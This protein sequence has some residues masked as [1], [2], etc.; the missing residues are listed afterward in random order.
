VKA[1]GGVRLVT[2]GGVLP[3]PVEIAA[4]ALPHDKALPYVSGTAQWLRR[5]LKPEVLP[6]DLEAR[7]LAVPRAV[8]G[9]DAVLAAWEAGGRRFQAVVTKFDVH[10]LVALPG[11]GGDPEQRKQRVVDEARAILR[12]PAGFPRVVYR[13]EQMGQMTVVYPPGDPGEIAEWHEALVAVTD[14]GG[15]KFSFPK[16]AGRAGAPKGPAPRGPQ[17]WFAG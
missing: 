17:P 16:V 14:G 11:M 4:G 12:L 2:E 10:V 3:P 7:C 5:A 15:V 9:S 13:A 6:A 1:A 8:E